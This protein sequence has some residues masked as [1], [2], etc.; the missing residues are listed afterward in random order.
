MTIPI[1]DRYFAQIFWSDEDGGFIAVAPDL[2]GCSA[3]GASRQAALVELEIA[4]A[5]WKEAAANAG[6]P[7]PQPSNFRR[8]RY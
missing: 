6:N 2:P 5:A 3:F 4:I 1:E 8:S 7:I